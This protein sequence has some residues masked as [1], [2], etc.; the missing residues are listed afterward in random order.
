MSFTSGAPAAF[1]ASFHFCR[2]ESSDDSDELLSRS[3]HKLFIA[4]ASRSLKG[5][6]D[7]VRYTTTRYDRAHD[8][9]IMPNFPA[10]KF[11]SGKSGC[12]VKTKMASVKNG[13]HALVR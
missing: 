5:F 13:P 6:P 11:S 7:R 8:S 3:S 1:L 4:L 2:A 12:F 10:A 9:L